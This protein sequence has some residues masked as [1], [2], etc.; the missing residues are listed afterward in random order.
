MARLVALWLLLTSL[1]PSEASLLS[2]SHQPALPIL[3][4]FV[5]QLL[6]LL[7]WFAQRQTL[8][9]R[10]S[11]QAL[12]SSTASRVLLLTS[13][14]SLRLSSTLLA[15]LHLLQRTRRSLQMLLRLSVQLALSI[16]MSSFSV[17]AH[18]MRRV[19]TSLSSL[20]ILLL[21]MHVQLTSVMLL[22]A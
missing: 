22:L 11:L 8:T 12:W 3:T 4:L 16:L 15:A 18:L 7:R 20:R 19:R 14:F 6:A 13:L 10:S 1:I 21:L 9:S 5:V 2:T 17:L